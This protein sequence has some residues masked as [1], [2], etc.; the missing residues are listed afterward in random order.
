MNSMITIYLLIS[1][2]STIIIID[3]KSLNSASCEHCSATHYVQETFTLNEKK[4][5]SRYH[6]KNSSFP[7][8]HPPSLLRPH[9]K[10]LLPHRK[11]C[12][13]R[14]PCMLNLPSH[15]LYCTV[16]PSNRRRDP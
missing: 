6:S 16:N 5:L 3:K 7:P 14:L 15:Q 12:P 9:T 8:P 1:A 10:F 4:Y 13:Q 2:H 11:F